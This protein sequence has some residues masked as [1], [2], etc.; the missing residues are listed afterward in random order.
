MKYKIKLFSFE[1]FKATIHK[2][3]CIQLNILKN[4]NSSLILLFRIDME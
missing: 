3:L 4:A 2:N 1:K